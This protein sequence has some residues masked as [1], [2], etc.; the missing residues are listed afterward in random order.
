[1]KLIKNKTLDVLQ[2]HEKVQR[3]QEKEIHC[4]LPNSDAHYS[5]EC[6]EFLSKITEQRQCELSSLMCKVDPNHE[7]CIIFSEEYK[8]KKFLCTQPL[9]ENS[10]ICLEFS[11]QETIRKQEKLCTLQPNQPSCVH[12]PRKTKVGGNIINEEQL[13]NV[14][15]SLMEKN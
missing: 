11:E 2:K 4:L 6:V 7:Y 5:Q 1:M 15:S 12:K 8:R 3:F 10:L 9:Q 14:K 13:N